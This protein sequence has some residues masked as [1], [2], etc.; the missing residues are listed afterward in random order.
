MRL[1]PVLI[2]MVIVSNCSAGYKSPH[3]VL[4]RTSK[5]ISNNYIIPVLFPRNI[6]FYLLEYSFPQAGVEENRLAG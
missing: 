2:V 4:Q 3:T 1:E 5:S 6:L